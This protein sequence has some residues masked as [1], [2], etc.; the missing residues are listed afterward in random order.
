MEKPL[1]KEFYM[2]TSTLELSG[3]LQQK[4]DKMDLH[5]SSW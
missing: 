5:D 1:Q 4:W 2:E 3:S